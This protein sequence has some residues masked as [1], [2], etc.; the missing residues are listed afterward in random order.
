[1]ADGLDR[2][3]RRKAHFAQ[4]QGTFPLPLVFDDIPLPGAATLDD[5]EFVVRTAK[6]WGTSVKPLILT[7]RRLICPSDPGGRAAII[8]LTDIRSITLRKHAIGF[9]TIVIGTADERPA[10]FP[11][12]I[13]GALMRADIAAM[14]D[15]AQRA[16]APK[17]SVVSP[18][19][20][21]GDRYEQLR[22]IGELKKSGVLSEAEFQEEKARI[23]KQT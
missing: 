21:G 12:H 11:A 9:A 19:S 3:A 15:F 5:D 17:L 18:P 7:T 2:E 16:V 22:R 6:D 8:P 1:M 20:P 10:S 4:M 14:A 13:N 23:L